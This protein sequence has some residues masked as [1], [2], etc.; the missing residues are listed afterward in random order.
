[1]FTFVTRI[2]IFFTLVM[3]APMFALPAF[4][5][6]D[7]GLGANGAA[8]TIGG[9]AG[10][11]T[12]GVNDLTLSQQVGKIISVALSFVGTLF[13]A[14]TVYAGFLWMTASGNEEQVAKAQNIIKM[15]VIGMIITLAA[16]GIT[17]FTVS[18][19]QES[20]AQGAC[21]GNNC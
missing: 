20:T 6:P 12:A 9:K 5:A 4:A 11:T 7:I 10:Y 1:M 16:Y 18:S 15:A 21:V 17:K 2:K 14:L 8:Q 13:F 3:I 19:V